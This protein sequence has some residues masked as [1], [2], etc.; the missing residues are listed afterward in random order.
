[1]AA[2]VGP[3]ATTRPQDSVLLGW[4]KLAPG[5]LLLPLV[6]VVTFASHALNM[7]AYP[8]YLGDEGIYMEQAWAALKGIGLTPYTYTYDHA[9]VGS[10]A[11]FGIAVLTKENAIL[12]TP[13]LAYAL[14]IA[15]RERH[16]Y[17]FG[18]SGWLYVCL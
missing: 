1:M 5:R 7:F 17:R 16:F 6:L 14:Y 11:A 12:F 18:V 2:T 15:S 13:V 8:L 9:L 3:L 10:G 4:G